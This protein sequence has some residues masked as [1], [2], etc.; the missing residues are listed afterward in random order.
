MGKLSENPNYDVNRIANELPIELSEKVSGMLLD[1]ENN[2]LHD[3]SKRDIV[4][5]A[6]DAHLDAIVSDI[7]LNIRSLLVHHL[8][9]S[10]TQQMVQ[11]NEEEKKRT[12]R[13]CDEL[14]PAA[15]TLSQTS[16]YCSELLVVSNQFETLLP[17]ISYLLPKYH[18]LFS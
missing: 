2:Q 6:K 18:Q 15:K 16:Q 1:D 17:P 7:I 13:E 3:W 8:I 11:A 12:F 14:H 10:L 5:K 9:Q 4:P